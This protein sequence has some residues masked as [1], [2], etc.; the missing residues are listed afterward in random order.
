MVTEKVEFD[1]YI[2]E[3]N[4]KEYLKNKVKNLEKIL[5]RTK[6]LMSENKDVTELVI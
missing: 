4:R 5:L 2:L 6:S 3:G 1:P